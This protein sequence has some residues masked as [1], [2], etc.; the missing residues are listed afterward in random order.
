MATLF[1]FRAVFPL[2]ARAAAVA[3]PPYDVVSA[4]EAAALARD[5][6]FSFLH[7]SRAEIDLPPGTDPYADCVYAT[8][9][10]NYERLRREAPLLQETEPVFYLYAQ[11]MGAH[12]QVGVVATVA[13]DEY[14]AGLVKKH[15]TTRRDKEEDRTRHIATLRSQTGPVFLAY[16]PQAAI[17]AAVARLTQAAPFLDCVAPDGIRHSV[18]RVASAADIRLLREAFGA[19]P[20]LYIADGHHRAASASRVRERLRQ[21]NPH[22]T[23]DEAC[24]RFLAVTFPA[25]QLRILPYN[26]LVRDLAG[27][28]PEAFLDRCRADFDVAPATGAAPERPGVFHVFL[29]GRWLR[30]AWRGTAADLPPVERLDVSLLQNLVLAPLLGIDDPRTSK[31]IEFVGGIRGTGLLEEQVR[32]GAHA[33]AVSLFPTTVEQLMAIADAG[34]IMP[35]KSTWF[36]PKL[37]DALLIHDI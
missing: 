28:A 37:R 10:A 6:P 21:A 4:A 7:V 36:E 3:A 33:L 9:R 1:P 11:A 30:L 16:R 5:N 22:H 17:D 20:A 35:P 14:D 13:L 2:P 18:W 26:R 8:A 12:R 25:N 32:S 29:A 31:R 24:N 19:V 27:L 34:A 15:E 23:G